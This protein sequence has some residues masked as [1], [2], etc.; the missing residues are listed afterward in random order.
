M[1]NTMKIFN[2][3]MLAFFLCTSATLSVGGRFYYFFLRKIKVLFFS[4]SFTSFDI[5]IILLHK[6]KCF[7]FRTLFGVRFNYFVALNRNTRT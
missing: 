7:I 3:L 4:I 5:N 6:V 1:K 2:V